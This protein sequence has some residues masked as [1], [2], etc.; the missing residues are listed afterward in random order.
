MRGLAGLLLAAALA[1]PAHADAQPLEADGGNFPFVL[2]RDEEGNTVQ[3]PLRTNVVPL[4]PV[5]SCFGWVVRVPGP[6]RMV[7]LV[8]IQRL[9]GPTRFDAGPDVKINESSDTTTR[10]A[11]EMTQDGALSGLWCVNEVDPPGLYKF[12]IEVDGMKRAHFTYCAVRLPP[13]QPVDLAELACKNFFQ[14]S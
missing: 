12:E 6:D 8:E 3:G 2:I 9:S 7:E 14:S 1:A 10:R 4:W 11:R 13:D 5:R